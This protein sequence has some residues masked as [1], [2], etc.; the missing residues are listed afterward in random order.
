MLSIRTWPRRA[1]LAA[2]VLFLTVACD[3]SRIPTA[4]EHSAE[5]SANQQAPDAAKSTA[6]M[7]QLSKSGVDTIAV[8]DTV[9]YTASGT[10]V[11]STSASLSTSSAEAARTGSSPA[12]RT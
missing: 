8:G 3:A 6:P 12:S 2:G 4:A 1:S 10:L 9:R 11:T 7:V 5:L